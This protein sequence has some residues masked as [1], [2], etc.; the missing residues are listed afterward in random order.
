MVRALL[1]AAGSL[2]AYVGLSSLLHFVVFPEAPPPSNDRPVSGTHVRL[3]GGS[4]FVYRITASESEAEF[5]FRFASRVRQIQC[6]RKQVCPFV[7]VYD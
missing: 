2:L 1:I 3:P 7:E 4:T 6:G 5:S